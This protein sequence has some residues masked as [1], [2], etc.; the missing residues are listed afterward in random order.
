MARNFP[1]AN[2]DH[3]VTRTRNHN[4]FNAIV[5]NKTNAYFL[6]FAGATIEQQ[7]FRTYLPLFCVNHPHYLTNILVHRYFSHKNISTRIGFAQNAANIISAIHKCV[8]K[9]IPIRT[10]AYMKSVGTKD[11]ITTVE[12]I[13]ETAPTFWKCHCFCARTPSFPIKELVEFEK[14]IKGLG[15]LE[16]A[17]CVQDLATAGV[18]MQEALEVSFKEK[19]HKGRDIFLLLGEGGKEGLKLMI[20]AAKLNGLTDNEALL[21]LYKDLD[22][23]YQ[24]RESSWN[25]V[26]T[27]EHLACKLFRF[28]AYCT[29]QVEWRRQFWRII[30]FDEGVAE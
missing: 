19:D 8:H 6:V 2:R 12:Q 20:P 23:Q 26:T 7:H 21:M 24:A 5:R 27:V 28:A 29:K 14:G 10:N 15:M 9:K 1:Q 17:L 18:I 11:M 3:Y 13:I 4:V 25:N 30:G 22:L 16:T